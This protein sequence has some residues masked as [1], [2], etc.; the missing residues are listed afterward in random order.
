MTRTLIVRGTTRM[1]RIGAPVVTTIGSFDGVHLGHQRLLRRVQEVKGRWVAEG[2]RPAA[3]AVSFHPHP[4]IVLGRVEELPLISS[5]RQRVEILSAFDIDILYMVHFTPRFARV[6]A[7]EFVERVLLGELKTRHLVVGPDA[8]VGYR[9]EGNVEFLRAAMAA[10]GCEFESVPT[11][12]VDGV[13][14]SSERIRGLLRDGRMR[15]AAAMLGRNFVLDS[16]VM[17]GE[18]RGARLGFPTANLK[19]NEQLL[20][21]DGVYASRTLLQG[22][23]YDS[24][25]NVG[26]R[27]TFAGRARS[28]ETHLF[29]YGGTEFYGERIEVEFVERL[30][31]ERA[32]ASAEELRLQISRDVETAKGVLHG[33]R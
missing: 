7:A 29:G 30:R 5:L 10:A 14:A 20:P 26:C 33:P 2:H 13:R 18:R 28:V 31:E 11:L 12:L 25:T 16:L 24:I 17:R 27:P 4:A 32:F 6:R 8:S 3:V 22:V 9:R 23:L 15:E 19:R 1:P 21:A